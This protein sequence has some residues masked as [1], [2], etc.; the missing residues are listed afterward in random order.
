MDL[1]KGQYLLQVNGADTADQINETLT[2]DETGTERLYPIKLRV[3]MNVRAAKQAELQTQADLGK[4]D[5]VLVQGGTFNMGSDN[6]ESHEDEK[7]VHAVTVSSFYISKYLVTQAQWQ[8]V[9]GNNPSYNKCDNCPVENISWEDAQAYCE[10]QSKVTGKDW[11][12]PTEAEWEYAARGGNKSHGY[13]YSGSNNINEVAWNW[14]E[15][16]KSHPVGQ[17]QPNELGLYDMSGNV[18]EYCSDWYNK[19]YYRNSPSQDPQAGTL[20]RANAYRVVR[21]GSWNDIPGQ[22]RVARRRDSGPGYSIGNIGFRPVVSA[23]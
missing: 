21:G 23:Q 15:H 22:C 3:V 1:R 11:R 12:L 8:A 16:G 20:G 10:K 7:P 13:I 4:L 17:K 9:M 18:W 14:D 5:L 19:D 6:A 2:V